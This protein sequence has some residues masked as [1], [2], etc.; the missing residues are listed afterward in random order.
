MIYLM[1]AGLCFTYLICRISLDAKKRHQ[2]KDLLWA[3]KVISF[4]ALFLPK[5]FSVP[6]GKRGYQ[7]LGIFLFLFV[8]SALSVCYLPMFYLLIAALLLS[9]VPFPMFL[10]ILVALLV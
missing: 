6:R 7:S 2:S 4:P 3:L 9:I 10:L 1:L 5:Y 8:L